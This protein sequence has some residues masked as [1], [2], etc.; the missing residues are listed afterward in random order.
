MRRGDHVRIDSEYAG[1]SVWRVLSVDPDGLLSLE[2]AHGAT[3]RCRPHHVTRITDG[4]KARR[5][6]PDTSHQAALDVAP[7]AQADRDLVLRVHSEH[8]DGLTDFELAALCGRQQTSL[9][10]RR[11]DL[12]A[13]GLI[14]RTEWRRPAPSGSRAFVWRITDE[15]RKVAAQ[16]KGDVA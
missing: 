3:L 8:P 5:T 2:N 4:P 9:G 16:L 1:D 7:R 11:G 10:K 6:D 14:E 12:C 15:G 13:D